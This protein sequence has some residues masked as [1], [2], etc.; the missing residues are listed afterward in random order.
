MSTNPDIF[1]YL[2]YRKYLQD[3]HNSKQEK[4]PGFSV[5]AFLKKAGIASPSFFRQIVNGERNLTTDT[6]RKVLSAMQLSSEE[7][8]FFRALVGFDQATDSEQKQLYYESLQ[9]LGKKLKIRILGEDTWDYYKKWYLPALRELAVL[10]VLRGKPAVIAKALTPSISTNDAKKGLA[11]L[12]DRGF[13][14]KTESGAF[15]QS[16]RVVHTGDQVQ[17]MA[18]RHFNRQMLQM[19]EQALDSIPVNERNI[20]GV[21]M[22]IS[23]QTYE[24]IVSE[25][26]TFHNRIM[27]LVAEDSSAERIFQLNTMIF[28]LSEE[29]PNT[30]ES[31][32]NP[33]NKQ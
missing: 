5:R 14:Q 13:L 28:P 12:L 22:G 27:K 11:F 19:A 16:D 8:K 23:A 33:E 21:T 30:M 2:D 10:P 15:E 1:Q 26:D 25:I 9:N 31:P 20:R 18:V 24:R 7:E 6:I 32:A 4:N 3:Y 17:S 29:I